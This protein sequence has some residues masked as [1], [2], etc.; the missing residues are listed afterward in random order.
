MDQCSA[1]P[2]AAHD[3]M[4]DSM[5]QSLSYLLYASGVADI[6]EQTEEEKIIQGEVQAFLD[7]DVLFNPYGDDAASRLLGGGKDW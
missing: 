4:V 6:P 7:S 3:D 5:S 1:F 2:N